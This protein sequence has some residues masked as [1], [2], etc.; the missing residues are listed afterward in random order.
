VVYAICVRLNE[1]NRRGL[2]FLEKGNVRNLAVISPGKLMYQRS[3]KSQFAM[4]SDIAEHFEVCKKLV[5]II[6]HTVAASL[7]K[8]G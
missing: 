6:R 8:S 5:G 1:E 2:M 4:Y 7:R 3:L